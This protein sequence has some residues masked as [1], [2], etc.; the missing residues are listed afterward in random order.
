LLRLHPHI[1]SSIQR[2][3]HFFDL[4]GRLGT[5]ASLLNETT[6]CAKRREYCSYWDPEELRDFNSTE[7]PTFAFEKTP[8]Y[9]NLHYVP[10]L[11]KRVVPW[12]KIL[13][14]LRNPVDRAYSEYKMN[15]EVNSGEWKTK[16][17][18]EQEV[19]NEIRKMRRLKYTNAPPLVGFDVN[20]TEDFEIPKHMTLQQRR[21]TRMAK[22]PIN[23]GFYAQHLL[24]W[25]QYFELGTT[26]KIVRY[27][28]FKENEA[29]TLNEIFDFIGAPHHSLNESMLDRNLSPLQ[30]KITRKLG[31]M[32]PTTRA[33]LQQMYKPFNDDLADLLG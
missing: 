26:L 4:W 27:E 1:V 17:S 18:F 3:G 21:F 5:N 19:E 25:M 20:Q 12:V 29:G 11:V 13:V 10:G 14:I 33:Y 9:I 31:P 15:W 30:K 7:H 23:R 28:S 16:L 8:K 32:S 24:N 6:V 2:E 22:K